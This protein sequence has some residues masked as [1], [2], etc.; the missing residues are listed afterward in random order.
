V[1]HNPRQ[2]ASGSQ[3]FDEAYASAYDVIYSEKDYAGEAELVTRLLTEH[4]Q[5]PV[6]SLMDLGCGTGR[7]AFELARRGYDVVGVDRSA[8]MLGQARAQAAAEGLSVR[9]ELGD[10]RNLDLGRKFDAALLLFAV[11]G[12]QT[13]TPDVLATLGSA[14][15]HLEPG[16]LLLFDVWYGPAVLA[17][18][19]STRER[20]FDARGARL[21]RRSSGTLDIGRH[22]CRVDIEV[23]RL[24][25]DSVL[26]SFA[27][28]HAVRYF[29]PL[30]IAHYLDDAGFELQ[31]IGAFP[32]PD[33]EADET[34]WNVVIVAQAV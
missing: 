26:E 25:G 10:V 13:E 23:E 24:S 15:R 28:S 32:D 34:T 6:Q 33:R 22:L 27:E 29:F 9:F 5:R 8:A 12:Y 3:V 16:G 7:H 20:V 19:P 21:R 11:L 18:K 30:E 17:L 4:S 14:R 2:N 31:R 1:S